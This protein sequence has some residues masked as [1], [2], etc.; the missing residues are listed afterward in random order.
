[1][2]NYLIFQVQTNY[3]II[4]YKLKEEFYHD[5]KRNNKTS[6]D[7]IRKN[8]TNNSFILMIYFVNKNLN[9]EN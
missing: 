2:V 6:F 8:L 9:S 1:M 3:K 5:N 4:F 7:C